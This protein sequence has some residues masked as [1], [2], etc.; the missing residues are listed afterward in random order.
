MHGVRQLE[1]QIASI[2]RR[3]RNESITEMWI[4]NPTDGETLILYTEVLL[5]QLRDAAV[6]SADQQ[7]WRE[8]LLGDW[9]VLTEMAM[10]A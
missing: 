4:D 7:W 10:M 6:L 2:T 9:Y 3:A 8:E 5:R 1:W